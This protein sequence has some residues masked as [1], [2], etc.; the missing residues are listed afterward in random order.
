MNHSKILLITALANL[1]LLAC[2]AEPMDLGP[3]DDKSDSPSD[4]HDLVRFEIEMVGEGQVAV[5]EPY[6]ETCSTDD[7]ICT[8]M[9][10]PGTRVVIEGETI[11]EPDGEL[12]VDCSGEHICTFDLNANLT[13]V[14]DFER[15]DHRIEGHRPFGFVPGQPIVIFDPVHEDQNPRPAAWNP[16]ER[17]TAK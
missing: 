8:F 6:V 3:S 9:F 10:E 4:S 1:G 14:A 17:L 15:L 5:L 13:V 16:A 11:V 7:G 2:A 12:I